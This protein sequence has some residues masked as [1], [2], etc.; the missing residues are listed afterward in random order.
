MLFD[1]HTASTAVPAAALVAVLSGKGG[2]GK[3]A[4]CLA[5]ADVLAQTG[6]RVSLLDLDPQAGAT[7]A[8]GVARVQNP[9]IADPASEHSFLLYPSGRALA[10]ARRDELQHFIARARC[11]RDVVLADLS[12]ALTD[13]LHAAVLPLA[14]L[15]VIIARTDAAGLANADEAVALTAEHGCPY[16]VVPSMMGHTSLARE[17]DALLRERYAPHVAVSVPHEAAVAASAAALEPVTRSAPS[18]RASAVLRALAHDLHGRLAV[19]R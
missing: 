15:A 13:V 8:A 5:L 14:S 16:V 19:V 6:L 9:L 4:I 2:V 3:T 18:S 1:P 12:P 7:L 17:A 10:L 11:G